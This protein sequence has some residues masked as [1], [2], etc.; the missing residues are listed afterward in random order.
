MRNKNAKVSDPNKFVTAA[1][2]DE[3]ILYSSKVLPTGEIIL[4]P[5]GKECISE[6]INAEKKFTDISY[7]TQRLM[8]GDTSVIRDGAVYGDFTQTP[9]SLAESLQII[10]DG[11][12]KFDQLPI[13]VKNKFDNS[14]YQWIQS[15]GSPDWMNKMGIPIEKIIDEVKENDVVNES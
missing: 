14:Y 12:R 9:K 6:K 1:G 7:I 3:H 8:M 10:I 4:T 15:S 11:Q 2:K 5:S 13:E